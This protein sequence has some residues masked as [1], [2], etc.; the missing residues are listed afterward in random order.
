M[1]GQ[2][3]RRKMEPLMSLKQASSLSGPNLCRMLFRVRCRSLHQSEEAGEGEEGE[4]RRI[5]VHSNS[6][7]HY[8]HVHVH[9]HAHSTPQTHFLS[10]ISMPTLN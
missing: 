10:I 8:L 5:R 4:G 1:A 7:R 3:N 2:K 9:V 6:Q